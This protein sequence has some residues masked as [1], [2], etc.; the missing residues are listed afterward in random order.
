[1]P[2]QI[3]L[4]SRLAAGAWRGAPTPSRPSAERGGLDGVRRRLPATS[5]SMVICAAG[6]SPA[7]SAALQALRLPPPH[8]SPSCAAGSLASVR[9]PRTT[10][11]PRARRPLGLSGTGQR[12]CS[13]SHGVLTR[14]AHTAR[15]YTAYAQLNASRRRRAHTFSSLEAQARSDEIMALPSVPQQEGRWATARASTARSEVNYF[16]SVSARP[17]DVGARCAVLASHPLRRALSA[18]SLRTRSSPTEA[19]CTHA[20]LTT[21]LATL[22]RGRRAD[23]RRSMPRSRP[24]RVDDAVDG[25]NFGAAVSLAT[26]ECCVCV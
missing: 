5:A 22:S 10:R 2:P 12:C 24:C 21:C 9:D 14:H 26:T 1:M 25:A 17:F 15:S 23:S 4:G 3:E 7:R 11:T 19:A 16:P 6:L 13:R 20:Q 8:P 18:P